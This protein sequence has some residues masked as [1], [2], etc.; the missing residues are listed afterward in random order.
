MPRSDLLQ[1]PPQILPRPLIHQAHDLVANVEYFGIHVVGRQQ[2]GMSGIGAGKR[3][4][5]MAPWV[6][7]LARKMNSLPTLPN[8]LGLG[9][10]F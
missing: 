10:H 7:Y 1:Q 5:I 9:S 6:K 3:P 8:L 4:W 2:E